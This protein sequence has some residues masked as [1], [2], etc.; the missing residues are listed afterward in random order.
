MIS[1][2]QS[3][4][5][6]QQCLFLVA[7]PLICELAFV[8]SL[9][10]LFCQVQTEARSAEESKLVISA[11]DSAEKTMYMV[12]TDLA[13]SLNGN[14]HAQ[15]AQYYR[16]RELCAD[17]M[18]TL[19]ALLERR[20][21][22]ETVAE[23]Q[24][25][26]N[27]VLNTIEENRSAMKDNGIIKM[28]MR[29][30]LHAAGLQ[31]AMDLLMQNFDQLE[32]HEKG[33]SQSQTKNEIMARRMLL[34]AVYVG[35]VMNIMVAFFMS[36]YFSRVIIQKM[37]RLAENAQ[38]FSKMQ[39]MLPLLND[40][41]EFA[42]LDCVLH[43]MALSVS[44]S[45]K[46]ERAAI[47]NAVD[48]ICTLN[49]RGK[50]IAVSP[51]AI[52]AWGYEPEILIG[53]PYTQLT[54]GVS[55]SE[56]SLQEQFEWDVELER[57]DSKQISTNWSVKK[58]ADGTLFCVVHDVTERRR[59]ERLIKDSEAEIRSLLENMF[60]GV[61]KLTDSGNIVSVNPRMQQLLH[62]SSVDLVGKH[63]SELFRRKADVSP[64]QFFS[65]LVNNTLN[66]VAEYT[67]LSKSG[68]EVPVDL[69]VSRYETGDGKAYVANLLD[70]SERRQ[71]QE[72]KQQFTAMISHD[73]RTPL[74]SVSNMLEL[75]LAG[76]Y[77]EVSD[78][79]ASRMEVAQRNLTRLMSLINEL[80]EM[81]KLES[82]TM[83]LELA[84]TDVQNVLQQA[85]WSIEDFAKSNGVSLNL[86]PCELTLLLDE[87]RIV[88]VLVNLLS[89][90]IKFSAAGTN[91]S[92]HARLEE[93]YGVITISDQ[94]RGIS[95]ENLP[96]LFDRFSRA[97]QMGQG[98]I[99][100]TGLGLSICKAI[101]EMHGGR[102]EVESEVGV[103]TKF[104]V[105]LPA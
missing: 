15:V 75:T 72:L 76:A 46:R 61:I 39:A 38:R 80:L 91:I 1:K 50:F 58:G 13:S 29:G 35:V 84:R 49:E 96:Y 73:L 59:A 68:V 36:R 43:N 82:G 95:K 24:D 8:G 57:S 34:T 4:P 99:Q 44:N 62:F 37:S 32:E 79:C 26:M 31:D 56:L 103:G 60:T 87:K 48:V 63:V 22:H 85:H 28:I 92:L 102:I 2:L 83:Q 3:L 47:E 89:N 7:V 14:D 11:I 77:G 30:Q 27:Q 65:L 70:S 66:R 71:I 45:V 74:A 86:I 97:S 104:H 51:S 88:Q 90:S 41:T 67:A 81:D 12:F 20:Y 10:I 40:G 101:V 54:N 52:S 5:L 64:E 16:S 100:S 19:L 17:A 25:E 55:F 94:G 93:G 78:I 6:T 21:D 18:R 33:I 53:R 105:L 42:E 69:S 23:I 98:R 9:T